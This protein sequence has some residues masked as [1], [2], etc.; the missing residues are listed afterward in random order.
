MS[1]TFVQE[2]TD[3]Q[4]ARALQRQEF[5]DI[6]QHPQQHPP[7]MSVY[8]ERGDSPPFDLN[9]SD[10]D[11]DFPPLPIAAV[12]VPTRLPEVCQCINLFNL[13]FVSDSDFYFH[14]LCDTNQ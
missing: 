5:Q 1:H 12:P 6:P 13:Y 11:E 7:H 4:I 10:L 9:G 3:H 14:W 2:F 8:P